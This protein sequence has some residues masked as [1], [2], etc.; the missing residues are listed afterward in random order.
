MTQPF[1]ASDFATHVFA[2]DTHHMGSDTN[3]S[4]GSRKSHH[5][6]ILTISV[7]GEF[8][9]QRQR[10]EKTRRHTPFHHPSLEAPRAK[11]HSDNISFL[12]LEF[13]PK[14]ILHVRSC[15]GTADKQHEVNQK[16]RTMYVNMSTGTLHECCFFICLPQ[17]TIAQ[18]SRSKQS[19]GRHPSRSPMLQVQSIAP[20]QR[21]PLTRR[22]LFLRDA[23]PLKLWFAPGLILL[24]TTSF[25]H[26]GPCFIQL[27]SFQMLTC[28]HYPMNFPAMMMICTVSSPSRGVRG[29]RCRQT[30]FCTAQRWALLIHRG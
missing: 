30:S 21:I 29:P 23:P 5:L 18:V 17:S 10:T 8:K 3:H 14:A 27:P 28:N 26:R 7:L 12:T 9:E 11:R 22:A 4:T 20:H 19:C 1:Q 24:H 6:S 16:R 13:T 15:H 25:A 2:L